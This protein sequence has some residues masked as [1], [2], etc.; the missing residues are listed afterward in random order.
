[1]LSVLVFIFLE[2]MGGSRLLIP[3]M[4]YLLFSDV[5]LFLFSGPIAGISPLLLFIV[6]SCKPCH[7]D[8]KHEIQLMLC[9]SIAI[10]QTTLY[11]VHAWERLSIDLHSILSQDQ[12]TL[13]NSRLNLPTELFAVIGGVGERVIPLAV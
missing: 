5:L 7:I 4:S 2:E 11:H 10:V 6:A 8:S 12:S 3:D 13:H 9:R 1:M